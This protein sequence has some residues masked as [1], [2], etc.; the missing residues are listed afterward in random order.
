MPCLLMFEWEKLQTPVTWN[1][2]QPPLQRDRVDVEVFYQ[3]KVVV[4]VLQTAQHLQPGAG[5]LLLAL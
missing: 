5:R 1:T 4:H 3:P 2:H